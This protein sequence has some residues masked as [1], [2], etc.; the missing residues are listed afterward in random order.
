MNAERT[1][2]YYLYKSMAYVFLQSEI[3]ERMQKERHVLR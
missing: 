1:T 3:A 2:E